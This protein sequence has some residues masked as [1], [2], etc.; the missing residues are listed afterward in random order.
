M[1]KIK[2][3]S[4]IVESLCAMT[5]LVLPFIRL[6]I[7]FCILASVLVSTELVASSRISILLSAKMALAIVKSCFCPCETLLASSFNSI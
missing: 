2:S 6:F 5:K 1:T 7:A 4:L 3:A